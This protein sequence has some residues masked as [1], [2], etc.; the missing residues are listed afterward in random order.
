[1][2]DVVTGWGNEIVRIERRLDLL[3]VGVQRSEF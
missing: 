2:S 3:R 1:M